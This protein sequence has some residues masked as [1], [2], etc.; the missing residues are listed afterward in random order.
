MT[1]GPRSNWFELR[2][3]RVLS[4]I[5]EI[6]CRAADSEVGL[7]K[8][9]LEAPRDLPSTQRAA[10]DRSGRQPSKGASYVHR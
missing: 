1:S 10:P 8:L 7:E 2:Q 6:L 3:L 5:Q 4:R 9:S